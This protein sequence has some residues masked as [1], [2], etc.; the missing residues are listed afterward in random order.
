MPSAVN[1]RKATAAALSVC[2]FLLNVSS[3]DDMQGNER[4]IWS[5]SR[6][7]ETKPHINRQTRTG[8]GLHEKIKELRDVLNLGRDSSAEDTWRMIQYGEKFWYSLCFSVNHYVYWP[9]KEWEKG[10]ARGRN[11][12]KVLY[13]FSHLIPFNLSRSIFLSLGFQ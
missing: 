4:I 2:V 9:H 12:F 5:Y 7:A 6:S 10:E 8:A 13:V 11:L 3:R 1:T